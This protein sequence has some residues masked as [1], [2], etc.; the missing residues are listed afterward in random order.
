M[1]CHG[2]VILSSS[3]NS[4]SGRIDAGTLAF[5]TRVLVGRYAQNLRHMRPGARRQIIGSHDRN[6][7]VPL[8]EPSPSRVR[9]RNLS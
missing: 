2:R 9:Q 4:V 7:L 8:G 3:R 6:Y 5:S 1:K